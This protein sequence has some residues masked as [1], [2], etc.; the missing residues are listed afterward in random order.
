MADFAATG[1][2]PDMLELLLEQQYARLG[3]VE[4]TDGVHI[5]LTR[6]LGA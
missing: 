4:V 6:P 1:V 2:A 5:E 3:F